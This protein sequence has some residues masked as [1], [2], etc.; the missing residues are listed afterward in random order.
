MT[1]WNS[2]VL[3][4]GALLTPLAWHIGANQSYDRYRYPH[5]HHCCAGG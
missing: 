3:L 1:A 2:L 5:H 4:V